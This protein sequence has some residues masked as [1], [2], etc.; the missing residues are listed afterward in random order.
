MAREIAKAILGAG[1]VRLDIYN[2]DTQ[3]WSGLGDK[4][5]ADKFEITPDSELKRKQSKS[6]AAYGQNVASVA[7]AKPTK[8]SITLS[9]ASVEAL[10]LQFQGISTV[11]SQGTG[12][13]ADTVVAKLDKWVKLTKR[14]VVEAGFAV[15]SS[16]DVTTYVKG[17]DY[18]VNY[19]TGE[20]K[21][22]STGS[23]D[24]NDSLHVSGTVAAYNGTLIRGG[25]RAQV[26]VRA[27]WEGVNQVDGQYIECDA[28]DATLSTG[29]GFDFL[30]DD[31]NGIELS[32]ELSI[33]TGKTEAYVVRLAEPAA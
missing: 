30:A 20:I 13:L 11:E 23:I 19:E 12:A 29:T 32:G 7:I 14:N 2:P 17:T 9:S 18:L 16:D 1:D 26:R 5:E 8:I 28:Y 22:L 3:T 21:P 4:L 15:K 24:A 31:F 33:P 6:R 25:V 10:A 27:V